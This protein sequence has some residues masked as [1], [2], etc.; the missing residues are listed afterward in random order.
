MRAA[1]F[2]AALAMCA[3]AEPE[4]PVAPGPLRAGVAT[5]A[6]D[7][8]VG[9]PTGGYGRL[10]RPADPVSPWADTHPPTIGVQTQPTARALALSNGVT[11]VV[12]VRLDA[13]LTVAT[14]RWRAQELLEAAGRHA[15]LL[16]TATH[17][18][19]GPGRYFHPA[20]ASGTGGIDPARVGMDSF[21]AELEA[22]LAA[23][24]AEAAGRALDALRPASIGVATIDAP[25]LN[26][27][28][29]CANDDLY[30]AGF[31]DPTLTVVR[32]DEV[33]DSG[34]PLRPLTGLVH[35]ALHGTVL[36]D[37]NRL[38]SVDAPGAI[39][40]FASDAVGVPLVFL[41]GAAGDVSPDTAG[42]GG[43][44]G[45]EYL[46]RAA[47]R[48]VEDA[49]T[50]AAP[51]AAT[52]SATLERYELPVLLSRAAIG[53]AEDEF[54]ENGAAG[55][56]LGERRCPPVEV[57]PA[58]VVCIP[59]KRRPFRETTVEA[60]RL[61]PV[62]L[63]TLPGEPTTAEGEKVKA[64]GRQVEGVSHVLT[65][66][67]AQDH[68]GY[69]LEERDFLRLGYE[70][71]VSPLGWKFGDFIVGRLGEAFA[72]LGTEPPAL[73]R[74]VTAGFTPRE[75]TA[76]SAAPRQ[77]EASVDVRRL[78]AA[79]LVFEGGD[80]ALGT[81][82]VSLE[83]EG[84]FGF[85]PVRASAVRAVEG[86][87]DIV[88]FYEAEPSAASAPDAAARSHRWRAVWETLPDT[89]AGRYRLVARGRTL[90][91]GVE[92]DYVLEGGAFAVVPTDAFGA[93]AAAR[94]GSD[95]EV[96]LTVRLPPNPPVHD[97]VGTA[98]KNFRLRD[99]GARAGEGARA[100]GG[101]VVGTL[102]FPDRTQRV[103]RL[104]W[105]EAREQYVSSGAALQPGG[106]R[107][108][109]AP[110]GLQDAFG[111]TNRAEVGLSLTAQ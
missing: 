64:A 35:F 101:A 80:P 38:L 18:H 61:G 17:T 91:A 15:P 51:P 74:P 62:L 16:L 19:S 46:G 102:T 97:A 76:S 59:L 72:R 83:R 8:P 45:M 56:G 67:Y 32:L 68:F 65:A 10:R 34:Q 98:V 88:L 103:V 4:R 42:H 60:L 24:I 44:Q 12:V 6:L 13:C 37:D 93:A 20:P 48:K 52:S 39:E 26:R 14:L 73:S 106:Y 82:R 108:T 78:E 43:F 47:A 21:D 50:R 107:L 94:V 79:A 54:P 66:G 95:G 27:D 1:A 9:V 30:G 96:G 28:R 57:D 71:Y 29:R 58:S 3:C 25:E 41:Q 31:R 23:S 36:D 109:I 70:P 75:A 5:V 7:A 92:S 85:A 89:P 104:E 69:L 84:P 111:N 81:P 105:D 99:S 100:K 55:C 87:P 11:T 86:G 77:R 110:G 63:G 40:L 53:Y 49:W 22:R 2:A 33:D 90:L